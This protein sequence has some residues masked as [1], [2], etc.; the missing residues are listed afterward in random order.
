MKNIFKK[1]KKKKKVKQRDHDQWQE[2][3][4]KEAKTEYLC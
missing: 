4:G 3:V 2:T 1:Y